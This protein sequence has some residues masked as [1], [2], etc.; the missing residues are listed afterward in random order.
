[1][2]LLCDCN[3]FVPGALRGWLN[4]ERSVCPA[5]VMGRAAPRAYLPQ[6][7]RPGYPHGLQ[8]AGSTTLK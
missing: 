2:G 7:F 1:M 8:E 6:A 5:Q 4:V 3:F